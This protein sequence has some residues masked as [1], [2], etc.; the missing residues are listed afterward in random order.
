[1]EFWRERA[2]A[3]SP[4]L[5]GLTPADLPRHA[6]D[7]T[8]LVARFDVED[9]RGVSWV[10][11]IA[12]AV[13]LRDR[14]WTFSALP[15]EDVVFTNGSDTVR[16]FMLMHDLEAGSVP[17]AEWLALCLRAGI[18]DLDLGE[19]TAPAG[20]TPPMPNRRMWSFV[21][22][23]YYG[24][25]LNRTY[26]VVVTERMICGAKVR[27]LT[28]APAFP[29]R[30]WEDPEFYPR[31]K[32]EARYQG[33][34]PESSA[35]PEIDSRNFQIERAAI[36]RVELREKGKWGMGSIPH[37]GRVLLHLRDGTTRDLILVGRQDAGGIV[38]ALGQV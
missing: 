29:G 35:F 26:R 12:L 6:P 34:D 13:S 36:T 3:L 25:V 20:G 11:G 7:L 5:A 18:G 8:P 31:P 32:L 14:G 16:P 10:F 9:P 23:E 30:A 22:M 2:G 19:A 15:G 17:G 24:L 37:S 38:E 33:V 4:A 28:S 27:G 1:M 21:A